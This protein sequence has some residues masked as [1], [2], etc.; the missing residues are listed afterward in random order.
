MLWISV[1]CFI[2]QVL[3]FNLNCLFHKVVV[4]KGTCIKRF[5]ILYKF[6]LSQSCSLFKCATGFYFWL[7]LQ[8]GLVGWKSISFQI[9]FLTFQIYIANLALWGFIPNF[10]TP[11]LCLHTTEMC[12]I[13]LLWIL[14][15]HAHF[16]WTQM[17][18]FYSAFPSPTFTFKT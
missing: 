3:W 14:L 8:V 15:L 13:V 6:S 9:S 16:H 11:L 10:C 17:S 18:L 2:I 12:L 1:S 4:W 7:V 5:K